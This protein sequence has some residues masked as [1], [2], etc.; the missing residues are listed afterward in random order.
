MT[1][2]LD[3]DGLPL[4][5][6]IPGGRPAQ[7]Y[8]RTLT[9]LVSSLRTAVLTVR[10]ET[11][12]AMVVYLEREPIDGLAVRGESRVVGPEALDEIEGVPLDRVTVT[13]VAPELA[14][15]LG[16]YFLPSGLGDLPAGVVV[17]EDFVR[18]LARPGRRGCVIVRTGGA[19]GLVFVAG[20]GVVLAYRQDGPPGDLEQVAGLLGE[21]GATLWAR[22]GPD[23]RQ[24]A[25]M[26]SETPAPSEA[27][28]RPAVLG[29]PVAPAEPD[30]FVLPEPFAGPLSPASPVV[31][32]AAPAA[33][34]TP[35][36][37]PDGPATSPL[38]VV[39]EEVRG[40]IGPHAARV[41]GMFERAEPSVDGLRAAAESLR[42]RRV[43]LL[44][45]ATM[46]LVADSAVAALER[47][48]AGR[49]S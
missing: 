13:E 34:S 43:R 30:A 9:R 23:H 12:V 5:P 4:L 47:H 31:A 42:A 46:E 28:T 26:P 48:A 21:P 7:T 32:P 40:I 16:S 6:P 29:P 37:R 18:S 36:R 1:G 39:I 49:T 41:E 27:P 2:E 3:A 17:A 11:L 33:V 35:I 38:E 15:E 8:A 22:L 10:T 24:G 19:V 14:R 45:P 44:S 20:G 25:S